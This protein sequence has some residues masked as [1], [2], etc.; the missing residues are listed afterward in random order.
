[1]RSIP[2]T[3]ASHEYVRGFGL[4]TAPFLLVLANEC[5]RL[6][7]P[8]AAGHFFFTCAL[9]LHLPYLQNWKYPEKM[10][11]YITHF[12]LLTRFTKIATTSMAKHIGTRSIGTNPRARFDKAVAGS[13]KIK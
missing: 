7:I 3:R 5:V 8:K 12:C 2:M 1:M 6:I 11:F 9:T 13:P 4:E 10:R